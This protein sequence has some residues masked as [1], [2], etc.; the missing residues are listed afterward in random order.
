[1]HS[2]LSELLSTNR[3]S[4]GIALLK[5]CKGGL[6]HRADTSCQNVMCIFMDKN[7]CLSVSLA[8]FKRL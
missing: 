8:K 6:V 3:K 2:I 7:I 1:M 4:I 5:R